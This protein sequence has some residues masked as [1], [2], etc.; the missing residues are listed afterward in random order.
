MKHTPLRRFAARC[1]RQRRLLFGHVQACAGRLGAAALSPL[2]GA[3]S[4][5]GGGTAP[6]AGKAV[7]R[8]LWV[9]PFP[10]VVEGALR[11]GALTYER[12]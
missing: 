10:S 9:G 2:S 5:L 4:A 11:H 6:G 1:G 12:T 7:P 3:P 8:C